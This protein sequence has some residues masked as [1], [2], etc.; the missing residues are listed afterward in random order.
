[1]LDQSTENEAVGGFVSP[2]GG[3]PTSWVGMRVPSSQKCGSNSGQRMYS[4]YHRE[5]MM[6]ILAGTSGPMCL[7]A[8]LRGTV[9]LYVICTT[10]EVKRESDTDGVR[11]LSTP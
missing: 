4:C 2:I 1:M 7:G 11:W 8:L 3:C 10:S 5:A 9:I 6:E